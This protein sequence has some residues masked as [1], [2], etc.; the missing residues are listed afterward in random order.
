MSLT[1]RG[2]RPTSD[3]RSLIRCALLVESA[4]HGL[5]CVNPFP[6]SSCSVSALRRSF[7][8]EPTMQT[9]AAL[10][11]GRVRRKRKCQPPVTPASAYK[12]PPSADAWDELEQQIEQTLSE[13]PLHSLTGSALLTHSH[14]TP[15]LSTAYAA[16]R[17]S[18]SSTP[19]WLHSSATPDHSSPTFYASS[20]SPVS[21]Y[22]GSSCYS[23]TLSSPSASSAYSAVYAS[24]SSFSSP[25]GPAHSMSATDRTNQWQPS[26]SVT[27]SRDMLDATRL[28]QLARPKS[29]TSTS[30]SSFCLLSSL[31]HD[32]IL[33][34]LGFLDIPSL[35]RMSTTCR[36][37]QSTSEDWELWSEMYVS[38]WPVD[39]ERTERKEQWKGD[40]RDKELQEEA[41]FFAQDNDYTRPVNPSTTAAD[42]EDE[43]GEA[44]LSRRDMEAQWRH[45]YRATL[46]RNRHSKRHINEFTL[47]QHFCD[48]HTPQPGHAAASPRPC[49]FLT[50]S[51]HLLLPDLYVC[52]SSHRV[53]FCSAACWAD[54]DDHRCRVTGR[55]ATE[56]ERGVQRIDGEDETDTA[57]DDEDGR[58]GRGGADAP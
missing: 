50:C 39:R 55:W 26:L 12:A 36:W 24:P 53:H 44:E 56:T 54:E 33:R 1:L 51:F 9:P 8:V 3:A 23:P 7:V 19:S 48:T 45:L 27:S 14:S 2:D 17:S 10:P 28:K 20:T 52:R 42:D 37:L 49:S 35:C 4:V 18:D 38:R 6:F 40:Y 5:R 34:C 22:S 11:A 32:L 21:S 58:D 29:T 43:K 31:Y 41:A 13:Q 15:S 16:S 47:I 25:S 30:S 46:R 57:A